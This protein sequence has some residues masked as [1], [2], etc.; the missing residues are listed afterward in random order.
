MSYLSSKNPDRQKA[1]RVQCNTKLMWRSSFLQDI[2]I[3][4]LHQNVGDS[5]LGEISFL[6]SSI[7]GLDIFFL[8]EPVSNDGKV[9]S[10]QKK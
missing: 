7:V 9:P 5:R 3:Y 6:V 1:E 4:L 10:T 8:C 2:Y